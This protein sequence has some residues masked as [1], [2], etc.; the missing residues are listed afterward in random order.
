[1]SE[2]DVT[3]LQKEWRAIVLDKLSSLE[4]GQNELKRDI[5]EIKTSF[6]RQNALEDLRVASRAELE[7]LRSKIDDL[8]AFR[9]KL[10][11][12]AIG[13]NALL[14]VLGYLIFKAQ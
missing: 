9:Y 4:T 12:I 10:V 1:M 8:S 7:G 2:E 3:N 6:A 5:V 11:G 14:S 13:V